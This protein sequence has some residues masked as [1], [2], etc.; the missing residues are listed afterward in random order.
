MNSIGIITKSPF[1]GTVQLLNQ[2]F[3]KETI[4]KVVGTVTFVFG[5]LE[6]YD[7]CLILSGSEISSD[8]STADPKWMQVANKVVVIFAKISLIL[9]ATVSPPGV[10]IISS[11]VGCFFTTPQ[12]D[13]VFGP[14]TIF[15][16]NP[17]HPRHVISIVAVVLALPSLVQSA[18]HGVN[19]VIRKI[20]HY[21]PIPS[22][23]SQQRP[24]LSDTVI[25][26][27]TLFNFITSRPMLHAG[28]QLGRLV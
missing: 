21:E 7:I 23:E 8:V 24:W 13:S 27:M 19:W 22:E 4:K 26:T 9:S 18:Y 16:V 10:F 20:R 14:N 25:R 3:I 28:N 6:A 17:W 1:E 11:L 2:P 15:A 12:L 5:I